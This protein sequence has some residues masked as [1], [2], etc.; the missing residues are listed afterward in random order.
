MVT[1]L[2]S[3]FS[4]AEVSVPRG[5]GFLE[6]D[7]RVESG[8]P[9]HVAVVVG[10]DATNSLIEHLARRAALAGHAVAGCL[11]S[12]G[13]PSFHQAALALGLATADRPADPQALAEG[14]VAA[15]AREPRR[16]VVI[17]PLPPEGSWDHAV[18]T[19]LLGAP[20]AL[21]LVVVSERGAP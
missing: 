13:F 19:E 14:L 6:L 5:G 2:A 1:S 8:S 10:R 11:A 4:A 12:P 18:M 17:A 7:A 3:P 21:L 9:G 20:R 15:A 16:L